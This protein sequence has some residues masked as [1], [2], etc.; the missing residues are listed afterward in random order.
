MC[1]RAAAT[2]TAIAG[3]IGVARRPRRAPGDGALPTLGGPVPD[4][5]ERP[6]PHEAGD[7]AYDH[8]GGW[9]R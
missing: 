9:V 4:T 5:V 1:H 7:L 3:I 8:R 2:G 6:R